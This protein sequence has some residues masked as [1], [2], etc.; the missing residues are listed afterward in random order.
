MLVETPMR[1]PVIKLEK[2]MQ[3]HL[4]GIGG[5]GLSAIARVLLGRGF[6]VSGSDEQMNE[7]TLELANAGGRIFHGHQSSHCEGADVLLISSAIPDNN[8]EVIAAL[9][10]GIPV[11]KRAEFLRTLM[12]DDYV[13]AIAGSHGKT[14]TTGMI[15]QIM[16][17]AGLDPSIIVGGVLPF[18]GSNG[19]AG[20]SKYFV[21][22]ADEYDHMFLGL[23][24]KIAVITNVD[25]DHP[26]LYPT[27]E[28]YQE[29]FEQFIGAIPS[30]GTLVVCQDDETT[31]N[32][33][34]SNQ[35]ETVGLKTYGLSEA[36][37]QAVDIRTNQQ[38]GSDFLILHQQKTAGLIRLRVPGEHNIRN[39]LAAIAVATELDIE[40]NVIRQGLADFGGISRR[41]QV[42]GKL[43][44][45]VV[46]DDYGHHPTEIQATLAAARQRYGR[47]RI[48]AV[49]QPHTFS[50]TKSMLDEFSTSFVDAD[51]VIILD[52]YQS[53]EVDSLGIDINHVAETI[54]HPDAHYLESK[55]SAA[56][57]VVDRIRPGD[58]I[59]TLSAGD[60]NL[61]GEL[62]LTTL[63]NRKGENHRLAE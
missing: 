7:F 6:K 23:E 34:Q 56:M 44:D 9:E 54:D 18:L 39:A 12:A 53:R 29:A 14:T 49:W 51:K 11:Y 30:G 48:W 17:Q 16:I 62:V 13:I 52:I 40:F 61:V 55:E 59:I 15:S 32:L 58:V 57:F 2:G 47:R 33:A 27:K 42:V 26:D 8:V 21:I 19:R 24:P 1:A 63:K 37:W 31:I 43:A 46:I 28:V 36:T 25:Y 4:V 22:E 41:F 20:G 38:G 45:V 3:I 5:S 60:G 10:K 50:R 35:P